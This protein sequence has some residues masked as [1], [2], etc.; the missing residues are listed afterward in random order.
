MR[1]LLASYYINGMRYD[2]VAN[3]SN[4]NNIPYYELFDHKSE[5]LLNAGCLHHDFP[6]YAEICHFIDEVVKCGKN[7]EV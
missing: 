5:D 3:Y 1:H 4:N 6:T 7:S 2:I